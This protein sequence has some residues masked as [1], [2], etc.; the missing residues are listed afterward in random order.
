MLSEDLLSG[1]KQAAA[2]I[3]TTERQIYHLVEAGHLPA[4]RLG[5]RI[6]FRK[7]EL[8]ATFRSQTAS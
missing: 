2:Y 4:I 1:A 8:D 5:R 3:G 7:S 6:Y